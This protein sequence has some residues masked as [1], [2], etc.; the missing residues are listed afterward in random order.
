[1]P[2]GIDQNFKGLIDVIELKAY[3]FEG[4]KGEEIKEI[5]IPADMNE[6]V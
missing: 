6:L 3:Q 5:A 4:L 1:M 2:I